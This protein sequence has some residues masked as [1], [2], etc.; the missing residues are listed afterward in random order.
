MKKLMLALAMV[1]MLS[2][3]AFAQETTASMGSVVVPRLESHKASSALSSWTCINLTNLSDS[4]VTV[5]IKAFDHD[6]TRVKN[7]FSILKGTMGAG[8][9]FTYVARQVETFVVPAKNTRRATFWVDDRVFMGY[10]VIEW[11]S[12]DADLSQ[13]LIGTSRFFRTYSSTDTPASEIYINNG[14]PF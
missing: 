2:S 12:S 13:P 3:A 8:K 6:G 11:R 5:T 1:V 14:Q 4:D 9:N 7:R 10:A